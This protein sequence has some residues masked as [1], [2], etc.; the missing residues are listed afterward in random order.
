MIHLKHRVRSGV[1]GAIFSHMNFRE[2]EPADLPEIVSLIREFAE[3]ENLTP[4]CEVD[5]D[6]LYAAMFAESSIVKGFIALEGT[7]LAGYALFYPG[8]SSFRGELGLNLEDLYVRKEYRGKGVGRM[9]LRKVAETARRR[10]FVRMDFMVSAQNDLALAFYKRL[11]ASC[12]SDERH[13]KF[14]DE[15]FLDLCR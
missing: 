9:L 14:S 7:V 1:P 5:E 3:F 2:I 11:G 10:G 4:Y 8:F 15:A 6:R 12:N 13:F